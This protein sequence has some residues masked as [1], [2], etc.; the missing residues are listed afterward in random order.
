L[1]L[2]VSVAGL[3]P[4]IDAKGEVGRRSPNSFPSDSRTLHFAGRAG[5]ASRASLRVREKSFFCVFVGRRRTTAVAR[6]PDRV[7]PSNELLRFIQTAR[8]L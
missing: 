8:G 4:D 3:V 6:N 1:L 7:E 2:E 5:S